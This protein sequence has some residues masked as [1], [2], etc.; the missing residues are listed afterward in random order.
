MFRNGRATVAQSAELTTPDWMARAPGSPGETPPCLLM[1]LGA[2]KIPRNCNVLQVPIQI[3]PFGVPKRG[4]ILSMADQNCDDTSL[5][6]PYR[7]FVMDSSL[8]NFRETLN[9]TNLPSLNEPVSKLGF[10]QNT[11]SQATLTVICTWKDHAS[12]LICKGTD[13]GMSWDSP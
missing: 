9:S 5:D 13:D 11:K 7:C 6:H 10:H 3:V 8:L 1:I 12:R 2:C 4:T